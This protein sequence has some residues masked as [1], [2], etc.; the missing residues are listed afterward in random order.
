MHGLEQAIVDQI[1][2]WKAA[3]K[4][5]ALIYIDDRGYRFT[6]S[7]WPSKNDIHRLRPWSRT[8]HFG[9]WNPPRM[10]S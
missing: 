2:V 6:G 5:V 3:G 7:N 4:P 10:R 9:E 1:K 8:D